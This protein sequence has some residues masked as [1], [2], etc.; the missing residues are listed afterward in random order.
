ML[1]TNGSAQGGSRPRPSRGT[2]TLGTRRTAPQSRIGRSTISR[3]LRRE[4]TH[5]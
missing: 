1:S 2:S 5:A 4:V 3:T